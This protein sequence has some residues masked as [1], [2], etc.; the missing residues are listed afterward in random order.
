MNVTISDP[1]LRRHVERA[2]TGV[3]GLPLDLRQIFGLFDAY[4]FFLIREGEQ[5]PRVQE[6]WRLLLSPELRN[7]LCRWFVRAGDNINPWALEMRRRL[8]EFTGEQLGTNPGVEIVARHPAHPLGILKSGDDLRVQD[9]K[10]RTYIGESKVAVSMCWARGGS[11]LIVLKGEY[12]AFFLERRSWPEDEPL[13]ESSPLI[14]D[15]AYWVT[16]QTDGRY[17]AVLWGEDQDDTGWDV[18]NLDTLEVVAGATYS[19]YELAQPPA[20]SPD[21]RL[22]AA[23]AEAEPYPCF[24]DG[25]ES[26]KP[27]GSLRVGTLI[28]GL[29][30]EWDYAEVPLMIQ[31]AADETEDQVSWWEMEEYRR[32]V[33]AGDRHLEFVLPNG[34]YRLVDVEAC[35][36]DPAWRAIKARK[37]QAEKEEREADRA[38]VISIASHNER[39][40]KLAE[41]LRIS[42]LTCPACGR[43]SR[44]IKFFPGSPE[45]RA[46]FVCPN[47]GRSFGPDTPA[48]ATSPRS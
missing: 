21:G 13:A 46:L 38:R 8:T 30:D 44:D 15:N 39:A 41:V 29:I 4:D 31:L 19:T 47:C 48:A 11:E 40:A 14:H 17:G 45:D 36:I 20:F 26:P 1:D 28:V 18:I 24:P 33:F 7:P 27:T 32:P 9:M 22:L 34:E 5:S 10:T 16:A 2:A 6:A 3:R 12:S 35:R 23:I 25:E 42:G 43:A 37:I